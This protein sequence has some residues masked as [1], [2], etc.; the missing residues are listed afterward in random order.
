MSLALL[1]ADPTRALAWCLLALCVVVAALVWR[2]ATAEV[3]LARL[4][5]EIE[6]IDR[7][8]HGHRARA[9]DILKR[10]QFLEVAHLKHET[11]RDVAAR[12]FL[13][14]DERLSRL[15]AGVVVISGKR[16]R[17]VPTPGGTA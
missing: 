11:D 7:E 14:H 10:V 2:L 13:R 12:M 4:R 1:D 6:S 3:S 8:M 16:A 9:A 15:E 17:T 5:V